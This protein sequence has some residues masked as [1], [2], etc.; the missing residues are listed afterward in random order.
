[1]AATRAGNIF[2]SRTSKVAPRPCASATGDKR[3]CGRLGGV[4]ITMSILW[5]LVLVLFAINLE[6]PNERK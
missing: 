4:M 6:Q 3:E 2:R 1:M 5:A